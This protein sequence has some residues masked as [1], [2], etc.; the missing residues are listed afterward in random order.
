MKKTHL[1]H[2]V[3][4]GFLVSTLG[5]CAVLVPG[6]TAN[7]NGPPLG[8]AMFGAYVK[9]GVWNQE[10]LFEL[11]TALD[12]EF[13]ILHYFTNWDTPFDTEAVQDILELERIPLITWQATGKPL[14]AISEGRYDNYL[15]DWAKSVRE[16]QAEVYIRIFPEM[17]GNWTTWHGNPKELVAAW[18]HIVNVFEVEGATNVRWV[19]SPN[20]TDEPATE[21]NR[22]EL[23][24]PGARYVDVLA[25]DGYNWGTTRPYTAWKPFEEIFRTP[26]ERVTALGRQP[27]WLAEV[28]STEYGGDKAEWINA[29]LSNTAFPRINAV[30]WFNEN[31]ETDWR[32]ES[33]RQSLSAF[34]DWHDDTPTVSTLLASR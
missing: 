27:L 3:I 1:L 6:E 12:H 34:R 8:H 20:V 31:K 29:M 33:S 13:K 14:A 11:E 15:Y 16:I 23:Y 18:Q 9:G 26:Y 24:Y 25:L 28:A 4:L 7:R 17:N 10:I 2:I 5:A 22:M 21:A 32:I 19:W 30:I